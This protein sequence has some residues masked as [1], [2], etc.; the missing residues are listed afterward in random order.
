MASEGPLHQKMLGAGVCVPGRG[1]DGERWAQRWLKHGVGIGTV[2]CTP[3]AV[4]SVWV[5]EGHAL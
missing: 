5:G 4:L 3:V 1:P 2:S